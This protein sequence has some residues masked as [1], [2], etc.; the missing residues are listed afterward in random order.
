MQALGYTNTQTLNIL[1]NK[2]IGYLNWIEYRELKDEISVFKAAIG[3]HHVHFSGAKLFKLS[4]IAVVNSE[5]P[6]LTYKT[7][8]SIDEEIKR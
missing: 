8:V 5:F 6:L 4:H 1:G 7:K 3:P 2:K